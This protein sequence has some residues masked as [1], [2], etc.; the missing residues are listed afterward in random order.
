MH[1]SY[2]TKN[3]IVMKNCVFDLENLWKHGILEYLSHR[4]VF[5][6]FLE[7]LRP[8]NTL[9]TQISC[10]GLIFDGLSEK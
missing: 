6:V 9:R 8:R 3:F 4:Q 5:D 1:Q 10:I 7:N 2:G